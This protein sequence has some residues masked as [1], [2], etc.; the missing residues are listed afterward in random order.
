MSAEPEIDPGDPGQVSHPPVFLER[1]GYRRRRLMDAARLLPLIG[2]GL[3]AIPLLWP[4]TAETEAPYSLS[5]AIIYIFGVW[6]GLIILAA[7][8]GYG[9][10]RL[11][12]SSDVPGPEPD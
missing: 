5:S 10:R 3:F 1:Q 6:A 7:L 9:A 12:R 11:G 4:G 8:F 2:A